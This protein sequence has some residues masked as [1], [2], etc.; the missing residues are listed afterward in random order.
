[1]KLADA[2]NTYTPAILVLESW[3]YTVI[4]DD[5]DFDDQTADWTATLADQTLIAN[6]P[7]RLLGLAAIAR[8][9][10]EAWQRQSDEVDRYDAILDA[11]YKSEGL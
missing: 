10:G 1:M 7:L 3:G 5:D 6:D 8:A 11:V 4:L 2:M 9:R